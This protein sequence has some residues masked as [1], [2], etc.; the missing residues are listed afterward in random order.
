MAN[1]SC[2]LLQAI[3]NRYDEFTPVEKNIAD[4]FL[5]DKPTQE[6]SARSIAQRLFVS[7]A[8]LSR[9]AQKCG[10]KGFREFIYNYEQSLQADRQTSLNAMTR[11]VT[12]TYQGL[13]DSTLRLLDEDKICR[14]LRLFTSHSQIYLYGM[15]SCGIAAQEFRLRLM[16]TGLAAEAVVDPHIMAMTAALADE[17]TLI[18]ALSMSGKTR[19]VLSAVKLA[20][21][22][23]ARIVLFTAAHR[24]ALRELC[25]E[26]LFV[27][28]TRNLETG[29]VISPQFPLL[30]MMD[31]FYMYI[32]H[33]DYA[34]KSSLLTKTL[35]A[36]DEKTRFAA[37]TERAGYAAQRQK[38]EE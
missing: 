13:L 12:A 16:R 27:A 25:D 6:L 11:E 2:L 35:I 3:A 1:T 23:G 17:H 37:K 9:F 36:L 29:S 34:G 10:Y 38:S 26:I 30:V 28:S 31:I 32:L 14:I 33:T 21:E 18:L 5:N 20:K 4:F 24:Q 7:E 22:H 15:G 8:S 19:E